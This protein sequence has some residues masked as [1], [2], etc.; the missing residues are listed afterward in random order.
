M[1]GSRSPARSGSGRCR[2]G[3]AA[4]A[5]VAGAADAVLAAGPSAVTQFEVGEPVGP[6]VLFAK[7]VSRSPSR[8][9]EAQ[10]GS[11]VRAFLAEGLDHY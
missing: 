7:Q 1:R 3:E 4:Q 2:A 9:V 6:L 11:G 10:L 5:G 8:S